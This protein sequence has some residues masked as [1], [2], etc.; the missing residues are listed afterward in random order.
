MVYVP[1]SGQAVGNLPHRVLPAL[2]PS[3][4]CVYSQ[5]ILED[6]EA[7]SSLVRCM[8]QAPHLPPSQSRPTVDCFKA[9]N[10]LLSSA[11]EICV[12]AFICLFE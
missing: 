9:R 5:G 4:D 8:K 12:F 10:K 11:T 6:W 3:I 1:I 2:S 7:N